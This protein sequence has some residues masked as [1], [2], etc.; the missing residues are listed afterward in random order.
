M[1]LSVCS[2]RS[3]ANSVL[4]LYHWESGRPSTGPGVFLAIY[5]QSVDVKRA[6]IEKS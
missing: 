6:I 1:T 5:T 4:L 3:K 2:G